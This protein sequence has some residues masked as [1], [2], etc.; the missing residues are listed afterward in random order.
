MIVSLPG[1]LLNFGHIV[2]IFFAFLFRTNFLIF[3]FLFRFFHNQRSKE[4]LLL[5]TA[6]DLE[7]YANAWADK[8]V[9]ASLRPHLAF[10]L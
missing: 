2:L 5:H 8:F 9:D 4:S 7:A 10:C 1:E 6:E 3:D